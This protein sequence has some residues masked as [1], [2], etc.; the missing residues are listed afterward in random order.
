MNSDGSSSIHSRYTCAFR[1]DGKKIYLWVIVNCY[2]PKT[3]KQ[4][5][6]MQM[7]FIILKDHHSEESIKG[8]NLEIQRQLRNTSSSSSGRDWKPETQVRII[9]CCSFPKSC[10]NMWPDGLQHARLLCS[11][12]SPWVCSNSCSLSQWCYLTISSSA[13]PFSFCLQSFPASGSFPMNQLF[14]DISREGVMTEVTE[15]NR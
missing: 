3:K 12:L 6:L 5:D 9:C 7:Q 11:S 15:E 13:A 2:Q 8:I 10:P 4:H 1:L 14:L